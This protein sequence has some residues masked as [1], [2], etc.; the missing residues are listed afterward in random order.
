MCLLK[1]EDTMCYGDMKKPQQGGE[2]KKRREAGTVQIHLPCDAKM[3]ADIQLLCRRNLIRPSRLLLY[4]TENLVEYLLRGVDCS[5][6]PPLPEKKTGRRRR[7]G[8]GRRGQGA[9]GAP[10]E[11]A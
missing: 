9:G 1:K 8:G 2:E 6:L 5:K 3:A 11:E 4:A 10:E 7:T